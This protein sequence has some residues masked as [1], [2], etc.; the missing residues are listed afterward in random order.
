MSAKKPGHTGGSPAFQGL[1]VPVLGPLHRTE[2]VRMDTLCTHL[3]PQEV[4]CAEGGK[5][6]WE[7]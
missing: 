5:N 3:M 1:S 4:A 2:M 6:S 7:Q